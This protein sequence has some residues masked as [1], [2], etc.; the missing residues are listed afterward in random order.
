MKKTLFSFLTLTILLAGCGT[1]SKLAE[2]ENACSGLS[3][4]QQA[5]CLS[6]CQKAAENYDEQG[7]SNEDTS[8]G[9]PK[10]ARCEGFSEGMV[11]NSCYFNLAMDE[12]NPA[13]CDNISN[14]MERMDCKDSVQ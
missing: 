2:C 1:D 11:R 14:S 10:N 13:Y 4:E 12:K 8:T 6:T 3:S 5:I 7:N 9:G